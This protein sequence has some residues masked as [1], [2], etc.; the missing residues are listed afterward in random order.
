MI[1][2]YETLSPYVFVRSVFIETNY[3][4]FYLL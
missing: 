4:Q 3:S 1:N 2:S